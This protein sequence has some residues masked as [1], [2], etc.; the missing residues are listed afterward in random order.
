MGLALALGIAL[1][2]TYIVFMTISSSFAISGALS[3][4]LA[5]EL[6]NIVY[7]IIALVV[8]RLFAY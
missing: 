8:Y 7:A 1:S 2:F 3:P 5:A 6:P 4:L